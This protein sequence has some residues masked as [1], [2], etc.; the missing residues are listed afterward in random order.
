[1]DTKIRLEAQRQLIEPGERCDYFVESKM[2]HAQYLGHRSVKALPNTRTHHIVGESGEV[3][4]FI[5]A[6]GVR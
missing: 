4:G 1:M 2:A 6:R 5:S 3:A